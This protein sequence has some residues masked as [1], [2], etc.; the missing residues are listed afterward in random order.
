MSPLIPSC[1]HSFSHSLY[2]CVGST[3]F[4]VPG[5]GRNDWSQFWKEIW[6]FDGAWPNNSTAVEQGGILRGYHSSLYTTT[7]MSGIM[8]QSKSSAPDFIISWQLPKQCVVEALTADRLDDLFKSWN[9]WIKNSQ[10]GDE[11]AQEIVWCSKGK[12]SMSEPKNPR[13]TLYQAV[14][15]PSQQRVMS[16][17]CNWGIYTGLAI[18]QDG[19]LTCHRWSLDLVDEIVVVYYCLNSREWINALD[20]FT[21]CVALYC[22]LL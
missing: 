9:L 19:G 17:F 2:V 3:R 16:N 14:I 1:L 6:M 10:H 11:S 15:G 4:S 18:L 13:N 20:L 7:A 21:M 8:Y 5:G 12:Y 22:N